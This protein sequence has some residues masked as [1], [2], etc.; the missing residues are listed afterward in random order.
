MIAS[1]RR[2]Q[3]TTAKLS[4]LETAAQVSIFAH[5]SPNELAPV[6]F[7]HADG[8][9]LVNSEV[10]AI[11]PANRRIFTLRRF[12]TTQFVAYDMD[13][14]AAI[15]NDPEFPTIEI[16]HPQLVRWGRYGIAFTDSTDFF[17]QPSLHIGRSVLV[18]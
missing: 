6:V 3:P 14:F 13:T 10:V 18:P 11:D 9:A 17:G 7:D 16:D 5:Q 4:P 2:G 12:G 15:G 1:W 8:D